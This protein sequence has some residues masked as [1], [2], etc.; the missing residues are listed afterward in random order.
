MKKIP[1]IMDC[2][3]GHDDAIALIMANAA[4]NLNLIGVTT[5]AGNQTIEKTTNNA[6]RVLSFLGKT[7]P[8]SM[9]STKPMVRVLEI[10][11]NVHG[12]TGLDGP[13]LGEPTYNPVNEKAWDFTRKLLLDS[14]EKVTLVATGPLTNLGI[15]ISLYPEVKDKIE[16]ISIM[17]GGIDHGNWVP[18]S[19]FNIL[20]DPEAA[21]I[22]FKSGIPIIMSGLDVTE[23]AIIL[24]EEVER[25]R[26]TNKKVPV[27]VAELLDFFS[28][29]H[30]E[31]GFLGSPMH[32]PC[33]IAYLIDPTIFVSEDY[34]VDIETQ[35]KYTTGMTIADK[36]INNSKE[37]NNVKALMDLDRE[38]FVSLLESLCL[39]YN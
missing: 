26:G 30:K 11:P 20:V 29:F 12:S 7:I 21:D 15:L 19:E 23:K 14:D 1:I 16:Q 31:L 37:K 3:P 18:A 35:G 10:A 9:G 22:V 4:D 17:G 8:V 27:F 2:D 13:A 25:L 34:H 38:R 33:A 5:T 6:L 24:D 36:R 32:D 28:I 39:K